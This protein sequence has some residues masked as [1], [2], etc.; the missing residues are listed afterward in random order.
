MVSIVL[1]PRTHGVG[2]VFNRGEGRENGSAR[3]PFGDGTVT[4]AAANFR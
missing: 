1:I 2:P 4:S 3:L